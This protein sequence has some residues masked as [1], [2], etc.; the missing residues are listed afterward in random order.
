MKQRA[1]EARPYQDKTD[2]NATYII[3]HLGR[4]GSKFL[5]AIEQELFWLFSEEIA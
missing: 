4:I 5:F 2:K 3:P 1:L